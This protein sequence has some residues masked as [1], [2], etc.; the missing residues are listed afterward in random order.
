M[1][2]PVSMLNRAAA[3]AGLTIR[4]QDRG[5]IGQV[6]LRGDLTSPKLQAAVSAG[7]GVGV[8]L[9]LMAAFDDEGAGA[10]WMSPDELLLFTDYDEAGAMVAALEKALAGEHH[11]AIDVSDARAVIELAGA[12]V[13]EVLAKGAP[14]DFSA[15]A[16]PVG[17]ARRT[18]IA[19]VAVGIWRRG[20]ESWE[21][22]CFRAYARHLFDWL[23][24]SSRQGS[25][26]GCL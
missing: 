19:G 24:Q 11:L 12:A 1:S 23:V 10:V 26:V 8:P 6:T 16:F 14:L 25:E 13:P 18:H 7:T 21:I 15:G 20:Q 5:P 3:G 22:V 4:I 17:R 2:E 9:P